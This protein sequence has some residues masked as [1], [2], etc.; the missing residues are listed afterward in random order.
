MQCVLLVYSKLVAGS[1]KNKK[2]HKNMD[3]F[4]AFVLTIKQ[5]NCPKRKS[6]TNPPKSQ[7]TTL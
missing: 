5:V 4:D 3:E 1:A 7:T 2:H 6:E